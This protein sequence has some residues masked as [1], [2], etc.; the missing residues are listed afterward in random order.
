M[1]I[2]LLTKALCLTATLISF[3]SGEIRDC[4]RWEK[5]GI[6]VAGTAGKNG[7]SSTELAWPSHVIVDNENNL[8]VSDRKNNRIQKFSPGSKTGIT[9]VNST[10]IYQPAGLSFDQKE[11]IL[12]I[13]DLKGLQKWTKEDGV[14]L[15]H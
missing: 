11:N 6:T 4:S 12:Y 7:S 2:A 13:V 9:I 15:V 3:V 1:C 14:V 10:Y 5:I 8:Y